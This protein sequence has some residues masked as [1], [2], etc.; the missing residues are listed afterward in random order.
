MFC[1]WSWV[2]RSL[3]VLLILVDLLI[4]IFLGKKLKIEN[5]YSE[6]ETFK[7]PFLFV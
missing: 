6:V 4:V 7:I 5:D 1:D 2:E 3:F